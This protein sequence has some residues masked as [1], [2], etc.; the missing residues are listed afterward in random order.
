MHQTEGVAS[1]PQ[2]DEAVIPAQPLPDDLP[3]ALPSATTT[4]EPPADAAPPVEAEEAAVST[5]DDRAEETV[6][7]PVGAAE[8]VTASEDQADVEAEPEAE[9]EPE[10]EAEAEPEAE[11]EAEAEPEAD[12]EA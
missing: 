8:P 4:V 2:G 9:V 1:T 5:L 7:D 10:A 12:P 11:A 3:T 6:A